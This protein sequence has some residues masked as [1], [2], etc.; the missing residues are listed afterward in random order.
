MSFSATYDWSLPDDWRQIGPLADAALEHL[1]QFVNL[2]DGEIAPYS[3]LSDVVGAADLILQI[4]PNMRT[5]SFEKFN[6]EVQ[7]WTAP[8]LSAVR[9]ALGL[10]ANP[11]ET[12]LKLALFGLARTE[13]NDTDMIDMVAMDV[14][15]EAILMQLDD[16]LKSIDRS[17]T[18]RRRSDPLMSRV[19]REAPDD[20]RISR[21]PEF[22]WHL[23]RAVYWYAFQEQEHWLLPRR[24][25]LTPELANEAM[26]RH[27]QLRADE[28][29]D[30]A[31]LFN[32]WIKSP[33]CKEPMK[34]LRKRDSY[35][36]KMSRGRQFKDI[37]KAWSAHLGMYEK[38]H[39]YVYLFAE[40]SGWL[41]N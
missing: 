31:F 13:H 10:W 28:Y 8:R 18:Q 15:E 16:C 26:K 34:E 19:N 29:A 11:I 2:K 3:Y 40:R 39:E 1:I 12:V 20:V 37:E 22:E 14:R 38:R 41:K 36:K 27:K 24:L 9:T 32:L 7:H 23:G 6:K 4:P 35:V 5:R 30:P 17:G 25:E 33:F 21:D